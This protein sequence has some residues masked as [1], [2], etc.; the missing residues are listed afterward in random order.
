MKPDYIWDVKTGYATLAGRYKT[1]IEYDFIQKHASRGLKILDIGGG[2]G[3][4]AIPLSEKNIVTVVDPNPLALSILKQRS[5]QI[6]TIN[7]KFEDYFTPNKY[8]LIL[9]MEVLQ[10]FENI[11]QV[12][13]KIRDLLN[14]KG[15]CIFTILNQISWKNRLREIL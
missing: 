14:N 2:S 7:T 8:D 9:M 12:F 11:P 1:R 15:L 6:E 13:L 3:R 5:S 10:Y 4:F